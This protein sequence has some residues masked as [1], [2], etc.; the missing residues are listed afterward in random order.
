MKKYA[1]YCSGGASR[2][3]DFYEKYNFVDYPVQFILYDGQNREIERRLKNINVNINILVVDFPPASKKKD[4]SNYVSEVLLNRLKFFNVD[5]L[6]CFGDKILKGDLIENFE[7]KI[8]NFH[9]SLLPAFPGLNAIDKA[10]ETSVQLLGNTAH[11]IDHGVDTGMIIM[12][13]AIPRNKIKCLEDVLELQLKMLMD[14]R[15]IID[16]NQLLIKNNRVEILDN[17]SFH[18]LSSYK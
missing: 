18:S 11:F 5:Y 6:F 7:N 16:N 10:L 8:I 2:I 1:V 14:I 3:L 13:T 4:K 9:P 15:I 17:K 12:Q